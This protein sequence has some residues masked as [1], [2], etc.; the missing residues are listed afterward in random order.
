MI[1]STSISHPLRVLA[2]ARK[3]IISS[4]QNQIITNLSRGNCLLHLSGISL[5]FFLLVLFGLFALT[6][7]V[8]FLTAVIANNILP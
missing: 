5:L 3:N 7:E 8:P 4:R 2:L 1:G 6:L